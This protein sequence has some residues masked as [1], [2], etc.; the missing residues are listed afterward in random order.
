MKFNR[1][2]INTSI[3]FSD[4]DVFRGEHPDTRS[5]EEFLAIITGK[6]RKRANHSGYWEAKKVVCIETGYT[7][8]SIS[9]AARFM[10]IRKSHLSAHLYGKVG[11]IKGKLTF[12]FV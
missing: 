3:H 11:K 6:P 4:D 2:P 1:E 12:R 9:E 7:Y 10:G 5:N 8:N